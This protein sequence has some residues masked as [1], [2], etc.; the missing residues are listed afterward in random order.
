MATCK[1]KNIDD[2][3]N[4]GEIFKIMLKYDI[5]WNGLKA[6]DDMKDQVKLELNQS[7]KI[8]SWSAGEV[9]ITNIKHSS[10]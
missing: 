9:L 8:L 3:D 6:L 7:A 5:S 10:S 2:I 1:S 4:I